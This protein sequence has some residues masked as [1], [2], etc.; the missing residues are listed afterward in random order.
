MLSPKVGDNVV[1]TTNPTIKGQITNIVRGL[2]Y[3]DYKSTFCNINQF[4][5]V[6]NLKNS[7]KH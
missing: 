5:I 1:C 7:S 2:V 6:C 3:I 4:K